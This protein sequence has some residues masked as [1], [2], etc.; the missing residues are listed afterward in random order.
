M[1][2][3]LALCAC[4]WV[5]GIYAAEPLLLVT[6]KV[7]LSNVEGRIDHL[8]IDLKTKRLFIAALGN[9]SVEVVDLEKSAVIQSIKGLE[10]PQGLVFVP[11]V[12]KLFVACGGDGSVRVYDGTTLKE[13]KKID[14]KS[15][16][17]GVRY[18]AATKRVYVGHESGAIAVMDPTSYE[19]LA[20]IN[21]SA[22]PEAFCVDAAAKRIYVNVPGSTT[23]EVID[24]DAKKVTEVWKLKDGKSNFPMALDTEHERLFVGCRSGAIILAINTKTGENI[25]HLQS[26]QD[27]DDLFWEPKLGMLMAVG[28]G[29]SG[30]VVRHKL[31]RP[32]EYRLLPEY[33]TRKGARTGLYVP[34]FHSIFVAVPKSGKKPAA[35]WEIQMSDK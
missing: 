23:V 10:E 1:K 8:S 24:L 21:V 2:T 25:N 18:D 31:L 33:F 12:N 17:D 26:E 32:D 35:I 11:D 22:H 5:T 19:I 9:G 20:D 29:G 15:D 4:F 14:L 13:E 30:M 6:S 16:A 3:I 28:G 7:E 27:M 34:E